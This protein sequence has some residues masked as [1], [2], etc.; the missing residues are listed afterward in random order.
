MVLIIVVSTSLL[1][2][3]CSKKNTE[4]TPAIETPIKP[5][6]YSYLPE[7]LIARDDTKGGF[8]KYKDHFRSA[9]I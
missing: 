6:T 5:K 9:R 1:M 2:S 3:N 8:Q 4:I 7:N